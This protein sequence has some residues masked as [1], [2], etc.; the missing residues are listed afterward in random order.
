MS[1]P[2]WAAVAVALAVGVAPASAADSSS[3]SK[4]LDD[5]DC[6]DFDSQAAAQQAYERTAG[7]ATRTDSTPTTTVSPRRRCSPL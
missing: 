7:L 6:S 5:V 3:V 2:I 1:E 4:M